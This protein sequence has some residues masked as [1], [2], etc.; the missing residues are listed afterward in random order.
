MPFDR[1]RTLKRCQYVLASYKSSP[2]VHFCIFF[3]S[4]NDQAF[5]WIWLPFGPGSLTKFK[6]NQA[7]EKIK[8]P[9]HFYRKLLGF[10][11]TKE[12]NQSLWGLTF[13]S[14]CKTSWTRFDPTKT[15]GAHL[16]NY[17][18]DANSL[19]P[20]AAK[21]RQQTFTE[22]GKVSWK[23]GFLITRREY[24]NSQMSLWWYFYTQ[25]Y[26]CRHC[27]PLHGIVGF[28]WN[29]FLCIFAIVFLPTLA[30]SGYILY[31]MRLFDTW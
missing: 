12:L 4:K 17:L 13:C 19:A 25:Q 11:M 18:I 29:F 10:I 28:L 30:H 5:A 26:D 2:T 16:P 24:I 31:I 27:G 9:R 7:K 20:S 21:W 3:F 8:M 23:R 22:Y 6:P 15:C 14:V 1:Q